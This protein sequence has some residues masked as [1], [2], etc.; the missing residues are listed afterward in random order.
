M[1]VHAARDPR[2]ADLSNAV[3]SGTCGGDTAFLPLGQIH[4]VKPIRIFF[5]NEGRC[6]VARDELGMIHHSRHEGQIVSDAFHF[7]AIKRHAHRLNRR[8]AIRAPGAELGNHGVVIHRDF[9][10]L[11]NA[12]VVARASVTRG[13]IVVPGASFKHRAGCNLH[14]GSVACQTTNRGQEVAIGI[15]GVKPILNRP[16]ADF[17]IVLPDRQLLARGD[18]D[19]LLNKVHAGDQFGH[20]MLNLK[21]S[22]HFEKIEILFSIYDEFHRSGAGVTHRMG[23]RER[24]FAHGLARL[25]IQE[26]RRRFFHHLLVP[27]L[28]RAFSFM[29][30]HAITMGVAEHLNFD[31]ARLRDKLL[32][33]DAVIAK[34]AG[35]LVLGRLEALARLLIIPRDAHPLAAA[36]GRGLDHHRIADLGRDLHSLIGIL[37][38][39]HIPRHRADI[40]ILGNFL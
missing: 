5:G 11:V 12:R 23:Q 15:F 25:G 28:N 10:T 30:E 24:L 31:V 21:A 20:R 26:R 34:A 40:G 37:N 16:A 19:H 27:A 17:Q 39:P 29:Q 22:V 38:E 35:R 4:T 3:H 32:N 2:A 8:R 18:T 33:E 14:R 6:H 9:T 13:G 1:V 36:A 7:E